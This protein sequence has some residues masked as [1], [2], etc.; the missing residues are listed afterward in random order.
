MKL[1]LKD[2]IQAHPHPL[3]QMGTSWFPLARE[4]QLPVVCTS[5]PSSHTFIHGL[6]NFSR[7]FPSESAQR[8]SGFILCKVTSSEPRSYHPNLEAYIIWLVLIPNLH[9]QFYSC[10][11]PCSGML[12]WA[13]L[14]SFIWCSRHPSAWSLRITTMSGEVP[15]L[16]FDIFHYNW[17]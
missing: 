16:V 6:I 7:M 10:F 14:C 12:I 1:D 5:N 8:L 9:P 2:H 3:A 4:I 13:Q 15:S 17:G 11:K